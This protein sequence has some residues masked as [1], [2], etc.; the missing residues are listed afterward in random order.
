MKKRSDVQPYHV[1]AWIKQGHGQ[2]PGTD[3]K[4]FFHVRD[5]PSRGRS[6]MVYSPKTDRIHHYLSDLEFKFHVLAEFDP[7]VEDI[8]EQFAMLPWEETQHIAEI[9]DIKHPVYPRS[10]TPIIMTSDIVLT[11]RGTK[12]PTY[13]VISIKPANEIDRSNKKTRRTSEKFLIEQNYWDRRHLP[14]LLKTEKDI[15]DN[16]YYNLVNFRTAHVAQELTWLDTYLPT[17]V[18]LFDVY[19]TPF[20]TLNEILDFTA[21]KLSLDRYLCYMLLG[22]A[23]WRHQMDLDLDNAIIRHLRPVQRTDELCFKL[24]A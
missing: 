11:L 5:V 6:C 2:G 10:T 17:F 1:S 4:P 21:R 18:H 7:N 9:L 20:R 22:R 23:V 19:W 12:G 13:A 3:Y 16:R 15:C 14:W 24:A 8:R